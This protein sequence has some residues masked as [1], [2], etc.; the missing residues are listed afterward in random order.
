MRLN[1]FLLTYAEA[2]NEVAGPSTEVYNA[3]NDIRKRAKLKELTNLNQAA[4]REAIWKE[5]WYELCYEN[6]TWYDMVRLRKALNIK[7]RQFEEYI[8]HKFPNGATV[9]ERELLFPIPTAEVRNNKNLKQNE[10]Y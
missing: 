8:G 4:L 6:K 3:V 1:K 10:G 2:Q 9:T 7:T 5:R